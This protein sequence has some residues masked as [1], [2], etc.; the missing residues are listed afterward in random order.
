MPTI[1]EI[2]QLGLGFRDKNSVNPVVHG[3]SF[4]INEGETLALV[5]E[6]GSGKSVTA[7]SILQLLNSPPLTFTS[8]QILWRGE[9][10]VKANDKRLRQIRG[11]EIS[12]IFQEPLT[13]L[14]PLHKVYRQISEIIELHQGLSK[15]ACLDLALTWLTKVGIRNPEQKLNSYPHQLS[16]G[17]RQ[18]VMI[19]MAL[20]NQPKL[21]IADE[22]T[23]AL[24]VS[25]QAQILELMKDLQQEMGMSV[26]FITHDL[27]IVQKLADRVAVMEQGQLVEQGS[28][29]QVFGDPQHPYTQRL[30]AAEPHGEPLPLNGAQQPIITVNNLKC[31]FPIKKGLL[32]KT[33][34][35]VK[36][37]D[38]ISLALQ[39]GESLGIVGES[40]SGKSTLG[41]SLIRLESSEGEI[42]FNQQ[43][44]DRLTAKQ[45]KPLR[46]EFQIIFQ[47]PFGSLSPRMTVAEIIG[48][49]LE[50][51][52][53]GSRQEREKIIIDAMQDVEMSPE[54]RFRYPNEFS[55]GQRQRIAIARALVLK[56]KLLVLDEPTSS[57]DRTIQ[58]QV[59]EL[60]LKLQREHELSY[61][62]ISH[63]LRVVKALCHKVLV[64]QAGK[65]VEYNDSESLY[66]NP[67]HPYTQQLLETAYY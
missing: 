34:A 62:F 16:G 4:N 41:R 18:R 14:N 24:D 52:S 3:V 26:L 37:V 21:L 17:E 11:H 48:E 38:D 7:L 23:T 66:T 15:Q 40:G 56:P 54:L 64:M 32:K 6:S 61:L 58:Q 25:V 8:G 57:L 2:N 59:I 5:G 28:T 33:V 46:R 44:I 1:L 63:D 60:L 29:R 13:A 49:G 19:A 27:H 35:H 51:H 42:N 22:P 31:W 45:L 67:Q 55:G 47:D 30:I 53:I 20:I 65:I 36:A 50:I 10:L 43:R 39:P 12:V 9:D